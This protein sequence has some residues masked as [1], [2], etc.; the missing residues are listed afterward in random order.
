MEEKYLLDAHEVSA[1]LGVKIGMAYAII[2]RLNSELEKM[3]K[4]VI[5]GKVNKK[6]LLSKLEV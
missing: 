2:R 5:R 4:I 6:Y 3:G 1:L